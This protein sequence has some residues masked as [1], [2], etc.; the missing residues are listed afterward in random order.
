MSMLRYWPST[1]VGFSTKTLI[2]L[3]MAAEMDERNF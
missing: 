2:P 1:V 3:S